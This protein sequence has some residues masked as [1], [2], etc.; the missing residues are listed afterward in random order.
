MPEMTEDIFFPIFLI[1]SMTMSVSWLLFARLSMARIERKMRS[2]GLPRPA[3][4]DGLG[5][6]ALWYASAIAFPLG[7]FNQ[8][9]DPF[10]D[11]PLVRKYATTFDRAVGWILMVS[12]FLFV[13]T[14]LAGGLVFDL[15]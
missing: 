10:I 2:E 7:I 8:A 4:W 14:G 13:A 11:V 12:G 15:Y 3:A 9:N 5:L 1:L 6:R